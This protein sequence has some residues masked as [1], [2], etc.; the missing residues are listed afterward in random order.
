MIDIILRTCRRHLRSLS[1]LIL[2]WTNMSPT[3]KSRPNLYVLKPDITTCSVW[4]YVLPWALKKWMRTETSQKRMTV[5]TH[6][7]KT[8]TIVIKRIT[9]MTACDEPPTGSRQLHS[10]EHEQSPST[11]FRSEQT[12][13]NSV[14]E[15][16]CVSVIRN[17]LRNLTYREKLSTLICHTYRSVSERWPS[18]TMLSSFSSSISISSP[19][20]K[21]D[22]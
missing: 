12:S 8:I 7:V 9:F 11:L 16:S 2:K 1:V 6:L 13:F 17:S 14:D 22:S 18:T 4:N 19:V 20:M 21:L 10:S 3:P 5:W 15:T